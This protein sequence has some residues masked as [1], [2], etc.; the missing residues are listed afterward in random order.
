MYHG[1]ILG[2]SPSSLTDPG[3]APPVGRWKTKDGKLDFKFP[4]SKKRKTKEAR[5]WGD[6]RPDESEWGSDVGMLDERWLRWRFED[7]SRHKGEVRFT[8]RCVDLEDEDK[9]VASQVVMETFY[10]G[11]VSVPLWAVRN[12]EELDEMM[13]VTFATLDWWRDTVRN[14]LDD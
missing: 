1:P 6:W 14:A 5:E 10:E 9:R 7:E 8:L 13:V 3:K 12:Q 4:E 2:G 11:H